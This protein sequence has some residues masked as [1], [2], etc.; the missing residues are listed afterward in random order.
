MSEEEHLTKLDDRK[1][2]D[3]TGIP[4]VNLTSHEIFYRANVTS[5]D[6]EY[7]EN[8]TVLALFCPDGLLFG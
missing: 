5:W 4:A 2:F 3:C 8:I 6:P 1:D 7:N